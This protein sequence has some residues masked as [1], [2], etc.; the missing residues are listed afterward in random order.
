MDFDDMYA[1]VQR[2]LQARAEGAPGEALALCTPDFSR[3]VVGW[4][5]DGGRDAA[6]RFC[7]EL[8]AHF[9]PAQEPAVHCHYLP[10]AL[11]MDRQ[12]CGCVHGASFGLAGDA[13][14]ASL[15]VVQVFEFQDGRL[16]R[17]TVWLDGEALCRQLGVG[18]AP[19]RSA[20]A[21]AAQAQ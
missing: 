14:E 10:N 8:C 18:C 2:Y 12:L 13:R 3:E 9:Q 4:P 15:R 17:E 7:Q 11:V 1:W 21:A 6:Q 19:E 16:R 20:P 5:A